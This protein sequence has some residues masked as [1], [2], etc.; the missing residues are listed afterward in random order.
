MNVLKILKENVEKNPAKTAIYDDRYSFTYQEVDA[1]SNE[2][3]NQVVELTSEADVV[4]LDLKHT[5]LIIFAILGVLKAGCTYVPLAKNNSSKR[6]EYIK[7]V[8]NS[9][10]TISDDNNISGRVIKLSDLDIG[11]MLSNN[12]KLAKKRAF[13]KNPYILFTSGSTGKPKG[14]KITDSN[15]DYILNNMQKLCPGTS[16]SVYCLTTPYTFDVSVTEIFG[17]IIANAAVFTFD[18]NNFLTYPT[19]LKKIDQYHISHFGASPSLFNTLLDISKEKDI[20]SISKNIKYVILAG[21]ELPVKLVKRWQSLNIDSKLYNFYGPTEATVYATYY[22]IPKNFNASSVP[23]GKPLP[24]AT[25]NIEDP[26]ENGKGELVVLGD[27]VTAGYINNDK[28]DKLNFGTNYRGQRFYRTGDIVR[29]DTDGNLIFY[30]RKDD[31]IELNGIR[32]ELGEINHYV[33]QLNGINESKTMLIDKTLVTFFT[34]KAT[35]MH[36]DSEYFRKKLKSE[37]PLYM[38]PRVF[39]RLDTFPLNGSNKVDKNKLEDTFKKYKNKKVNSQKVNTNIEE[40]LLSFFQES[41][42]KSLTL[43]DDLFESGADSLNIVSCIIKLEEYLKVSIDI[44]DFYLYRTPRKILNHLLQNNINSESIDDIEKNVNKVYLPVLNQKIQTTNAS[45]TQRLYFFKKKKNILT[46]DVKLPRDISINSI[47]QALNN[48]TMLNPVLRSSL[49]Q[50]GK[51]LQFNIYKTIKFDSSLVFNMAKEHEILN[52]M[53]EMGFKSRYQN[54]PLINMSIFQNKK[55]RKAIFI[56]DH[57]IFDASSVSIF[58]D[59]FIKALLGGV[60][61]KRGIDY[62]KYYHKLENSNSLEEIEKHPYIKEIRQANLEE[63]NL[64]SKIPK[65]MSHLEITNITNYKGDKLSYLISYLSSKQLAKLG[66]INSVTTNLILNLREYDAFSMKDTIGDVHSTIQLIYNGENLQDYCAK[67]DYNIKHY[68][69]DEL[70]SP[71]S[72]VYK[73]YPYL[74]VRQKAIRKV[75]GEDIPISI[76]FIGTISPEQMEHF[77]ESI[78]IM[79]KELAKTADL[80]R[81]YATAVLC[82]NKLHIFYDHKVYQDFQVLDFSEIK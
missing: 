47:Y 6:N 45:Y 76:S 72:V 16:D 79:Q 13:P 36:L 22:R 66:K 7:K 20:E 19:L 15:L 18:I 37:M 23:I 10:L 57:C 31:Q 61:K 58:K 29:L 53:L 40:R 11:M 30:G 21:E 73:N 80:S 49:Q 43:D 82:G 28:L 52:K 77:E 51:E 34:S 38:V 14:V 69:I 17:W 65:G 24:N 62:I 41:L 59:E 71:R 67:A 64:L 39:I 81:I 50:N 74:S 2:I 9:V 68:F 35:N 54:G 33:S 44:D 3:A 32:V 60:N 48:V 56:V 78:R 70:F 8:T 25:I 12:S 75:I 63:K 46:F 27:G 42:S 1:I 26:D 55:S 5:Y 4:T